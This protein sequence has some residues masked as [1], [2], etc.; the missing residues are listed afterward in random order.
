MLFQSA[1]TAI[2]FEAA[3]TD[4][5]ISRASGKLNL[6]DVHHTTQT[7][8]TYKEKLHVAMRACNL[9]DFSAPFSS[10]GVS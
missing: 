9:G 4:C 1:C 5:S 7:E 3:D 6:T 10:A 8:L 2:I